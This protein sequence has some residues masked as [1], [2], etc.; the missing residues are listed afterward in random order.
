MQVPLPQS[1]T[2]GSRLSLTDLLAWGLGLG[3]KFLRTSLHIPGHLNSVPTAGLAL[4]QDPHFTV[5]KCE[6]D[7]LCPSFRCLPNYCEHEGTC[8]QTW[9]A[10]HCDCGST[11][12]TGATCHRCK[13][14]LS[15]GSTPVTSISNFPLRV[16]TAASAQGKEGR[17]WWGPVAPALT[18]HT[19]QRALHGE[20][21]GPAP[22]T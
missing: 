18:L 3:E 5:T 17:R 4:P 19:Y 15:P 13:R 22:L 20:P 16:H 12:Y 6:H 9:T 10:F 1:Q 14:L 11:G 7:H 8:S 2:Q 21:L